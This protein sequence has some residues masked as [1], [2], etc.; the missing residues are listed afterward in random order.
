MNLSMA[1]EIGPSQDQMVIQED[2]LEHVE[3][4]YASPPGP[5]GKD[6]QERLDIQGAEKAFNRNNRKQY[7]AKQ[8]HQA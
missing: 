6:R 7:Q 4:S 5:D 3:Q 8:Q 1:G 2:L